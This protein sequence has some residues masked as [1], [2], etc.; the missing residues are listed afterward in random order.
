MRWLIAFITSFLL[1]GSVL[2]ADGAPDK[3]D[4][5]IAMKT[6]P[7]GVVIEVV[8]GDPNALD[9]ALPQVKRISADLHARFPDLPIAVVTHGAEQFALMNNAE[10]PLAGKIRQQ[11]RA[12]ADSGTPV[13]V[14]GGHAAIRGIDASAFPDYIDVAPSGPAQITDY[15]NQG[16]ALIILRNP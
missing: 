8:E 9:W 10:A 4:R 11:A 1:A 12:L 6:P 15:R 2:A 5:I 16:Y 14:C 7:A 3:L 13:H